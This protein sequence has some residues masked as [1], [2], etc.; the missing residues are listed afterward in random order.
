MRKGTVTRR[1]SQEG[2]DNFDISPVIGFGGYVSSL[3]PTIADPKLLVRG[4]YNVYK[5]ISGTIA[6]RPGRKLY[7]ATKDTTVKKITSGKVWNTSLGATFILRAAN[8]KLQFYSAISG[9]GT[10]YDLLTALTKERFVFDTYWDNTDKKDKLLSVNGTAQTVYDWAGG[11][12]LFVSAINN[13]SITMDRNTATAGFA[14]TGTVVI[15]GNTYAYTGI[16]GNTLTGVT[17]DASAE[18][19]N[20]VCFSQ[21]KTVTSFT[22]GPGTTYNCD[23]IKVVQNQLYLGSYTSQLIYLS[24]NTSYTDFSFSATR[25]TGEGDQILLDSSPTGIGQTDGNA[26]IFY[27]TSRLSQITFAQITVG[28]VLS[29]QTKQ[30]KVFLGNNCSAYAHEFIDQLGGNI[31]YLDQAQQLRTYGLFSNLFKAKPVMLSQAVQDEMAEETFTGGSLAVQSDRRGDIVYINAPVSGKTYVYQERSTLD[32]FGRVSTERLWQPPQTWNITRVD[33]VSGKTIGFSNSNPQCYYLWDTGQ[34]HDDAPAASVPYQSIALFSYENIG[35]RQGKLTFDKIY[36][37]GYMIQ[38]SHLYGG[39]YYD[40]QGST[41][42]LSPIIN[43][44]TSL[45]TD[46][47]GGTSRQIFT[48]VAPPSLGDASL[49]DA[50]LGDGLNILPNDQATVPKFRCVTGVQLLDCFE[51]ALMVYSTNLDARWEILALGTNMSL[52]TD[53]AVELQK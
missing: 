53:H 32:P 27:G 37:E 39:V 24:K 11:V 29:E 22:S 45:L 42:L 38:N 6:N 17:G 41:T 35:R 21:I 7:D 19:L 26:A 47:S 3:D 49:G 43:D 52:S 15:N 36:W 12:A 28:S 10:W 5:K 51:F 25:L 13:T 34:W 2:T 9:T 44:P 40:Y 48:G 16:S 1:V 46:G 4:S 20:S 14:S 30:G 18:A 33:A 31:L 8:A 23:F 50:P